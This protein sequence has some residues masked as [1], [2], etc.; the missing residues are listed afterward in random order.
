[1]KSYTQT[2][3]ITWLEQIGLQLYIQ[4]YIYTCIQQSKKRRPWIWG[5][6]GLGKV[7]GMKG[8]GKAS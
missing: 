7:G 5:E 6:E 8:K 3:N 1:M 4:E 2:Y